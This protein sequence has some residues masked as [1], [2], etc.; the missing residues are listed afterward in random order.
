MKN[1]NKKQ[2][3]CFGIKTDVFSTRKSFWKFNSQ[4]KKKKKKK[5]FYFYSFSLLISQAW[6]QLTKME[7]S[8]LWMFHRNGEEMYGMSSPTQIDLAF[9]TT[10]ISTS[11]IFLFSII[12]FLS[13]IFKIDLIGIKGIAFICFWIWNHF[14][15]RKNTFFPIVFNAKKALINFQKRF[16]VESEYPSHSFFNWI[17][18][19][20]IPPLSKWKDL[21]AKLIQSDTQ[22]AS[23][24][25][26]WERVAN[27]RTN[28]K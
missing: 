9:L 8:I 3:D 4:K 19:I 18:L 22:L 26:N 5:S 6:S 10:S 28:W 13:F 20:I 24:N 15:K 27:W 2:I 7:Y 11:C 1:L 17:C 14:S 21:S 25:K 16:Y 12:C 23:I